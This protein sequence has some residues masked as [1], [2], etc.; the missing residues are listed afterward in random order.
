MC[1]TPLPLSFIVGSSRL[2]V[3]TVLVVPVDQCLKSLL[4][5][6]ARTRRVF[7]RPVIV[8][9]FLVERSLSSRASVVCSVGRGFPLMRLAM[10]WRATPSTAASLLRESRKSPGLP[11]VSSNFAG[12]SQEAD[13]DCLINSSGGGAK[14]TTRFEGKKNTYLSNFNIIS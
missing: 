4:T 13:T 6:P 2:A 5:I 12:R 14:T 7:I 1:V 3:V 11:P 10:A 8:R 9:N